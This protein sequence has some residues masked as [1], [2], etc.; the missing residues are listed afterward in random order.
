MNNKLFLGLLL[1]CI[2]LPL[3][4]AK[5]AIKN[6][7]SEVVFV[8]LGNQKRKTI[9]R[10]RI[11]ATEERPPLFKE[12]SIMYPD[13]NRVG[14]HNTIKVSY[15]RKK[16]PAQEVTFARVNGT[17]EITGTVK[18]LQKQVREVAKQYGNI[19]LALLARKLIWKERKLERKETRKVTKQEKLLDRMK[20]RSGQRKEKRRS[21]TYKAIYINGWNPI[22][23]IKKWHYTANAVFSIQI[24]IIET[25]TYKRK[26]SKGMVALNG[27]KDVTEL[28]F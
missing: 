8:R 28:S 23:T 3:I 10:K 4:P 21:Y 5:L 17:K 15:A 9:F 7:S 6:Q 11:R 13:F 20:I 2:A 12:P 14:P 26:K 27:W 16:E 1:S 19:Q 24:P 22:T 18:E 25:F